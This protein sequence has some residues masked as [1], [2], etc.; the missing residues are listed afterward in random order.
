MIDSKK[1]L[2]ARFECETDIRLEPV[3]E[4][5]QQ[6]AIWLE[7]DVASRLNAETAAEN[8]LLREVFFRVSDLLEQAIT[9][10]VAVGK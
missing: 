10:P 5:W 3:P 4:N 9:R 7:K 6:Y 2:R 8:Y 1:E